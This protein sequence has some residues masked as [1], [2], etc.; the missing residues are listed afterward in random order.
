MVGSQLLKYCHFIED[1]QGHRMELRYIRD[2][3]GRELDFIVVKDNAPLFAV[4]CRVA[5]TTLVPAIKYFKER[6][7][8]PEFYQV[9]LGT[10]D[11]GSAHRGGRSLPFW[12]FFQVKQ[13]P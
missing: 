12:K 1:T 5:E 3:D 2:R 13:M 10:Q 8:I 7:A 9:H 4:E 11:I 6:T